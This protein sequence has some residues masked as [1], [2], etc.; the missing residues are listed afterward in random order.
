MASIITGDDLKALVGTVIGEGVVENADGI[1]Y[2]FR[3]GSSILKAKNR[4]PIDIDTYADKS[5]LVVEPGEVVF[6]LS[7][8]RIELPADVFAQLS[9]KRSLSQAGIMV[10]G[11]F[12]VDPGYS[13]RLLMGLYNFSS[14]VFP[15]IAD[16]K[17]IAASFFRLEDG[18]RGEFVTPRRL[19]DFPNELVEVMAKYQPVALQSLTEGLDALRFELAAVRKEL[20]SHTVWYDKFETALDRHNE[21]IGSLVGSLASE[22][23]ARKHGEDTISETV[24]QLQG[25]FTFMKG[26]AYVLG[27]L[28]TAIAIPLLVSWISTF[29]AK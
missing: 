4:V 22:Q 29:F 9:P 26:A 10:L 13:G 14:I 12:T 2:D 17:L 6:V 1:K 24:K 20:D 25:S 21:Q 7:R 8:E 15:L 11:G 27:I 16:R 5:Q 3:M 19:D 18:E 23:D 28:L